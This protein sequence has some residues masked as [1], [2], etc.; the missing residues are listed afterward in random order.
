MEKHSR[1]Y[2]AI[3]HYIK[4][5]ATPKKLGR[6]IYHNEPYS[7]NTRKIVKLIQKHNLTPIPLSHYRK[8]QAIEDNRPYIIDNGYTPAR[9]LYKGGTYT[10]KD[11]K[12]LIRA[13][14]QD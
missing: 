8:M 13:L 2:M 3:E 10:R 14:M 1:Q 7:T 11:F 6:V 12:A 4:E 9:W 5:T